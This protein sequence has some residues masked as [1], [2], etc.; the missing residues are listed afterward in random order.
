MAAPMEM[1]K[2]A[3]AYFIWFNDQREAIQKQLGTKSLGEVGKK[4]GEMWKSMS[5][6]A[7]LPWETK[8]KEQ[9]EAFEKFKATAAGQKALQEKKEA[10]QEAKEA[11]VKKDAKKAVKA[12]EKDDKLKKP[13]SAYFLFANAKR[14]EIQKLLGTKE[15]G[16]VT[17]KTTEMWKGLSASDRKPWDDQAQQQKDAYEKYIKTPEGAAALQAYKDEVKEAKADVK[18]KRVSDS[19]G[20]EAKRAKTSAAGA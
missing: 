7:K 17:K 20:P 12:I 6:T 5:A 1:K 16:P 9:K 8:A 14:E 11:K 15:F 3:S 19:D 2:P 13:A 18:G 10:K 4:A